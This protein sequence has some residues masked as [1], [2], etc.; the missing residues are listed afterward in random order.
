MK[1]G[2]DCSQSEL[3]AHYGVLRMPALMGSGTVTVFIAQ[4]ELEA[5]NDL[6]VL[7]TAVVVVFKPTSNVLSLMFIPR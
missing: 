2:S 5:K 1:V 6:K 3:L 4:R 7:H